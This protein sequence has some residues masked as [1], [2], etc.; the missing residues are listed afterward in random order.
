MSRRQNQPK[1]KGRQPKAK[2]PMLRN[3]PSFPGQPMAQHIVETFNE[4]FSTTVTTGA[5]AEVTPMDPTTQITNWATRF[6]SLY[7]EYRVVKAVARVL[8]FSST[9]PGTLMMFWD[10]K[11][12]TVPTNAAASERAL[13]RFNAGDVTRPHK[14]TWV[15]RDLLDLQYTPTGTAS[16]PVYW[17]IFTNNANNGSSIVATAYCT[18]DFKLT[19]QFRGFQ[20]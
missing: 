4:V 16:N 12:A 6:Q 19:I 20:T 10:E 15:A 13:V 1:R 17:K 9:N 14:T 8:C 5:I 11:S 3:I 18:V 2:L 7:E